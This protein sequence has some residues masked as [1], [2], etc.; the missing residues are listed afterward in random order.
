MNV[1]KENSQY[2]VH[3]NNLEKNGAR[4]WHETKKKHHAPLLTPTIDGSYH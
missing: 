1:P 4:L 2:N 3:C